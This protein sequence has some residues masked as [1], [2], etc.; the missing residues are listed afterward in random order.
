[1]PGRVEDPGAAYGYE[2]YPLEVMAAS[3]A[4]YCSALSG[5]SVKEPET[6]SREQY[7]PSAVLV[8]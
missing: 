6:S 1:V 5:L 4:A 2:Q 3:Q 7:P 8:R